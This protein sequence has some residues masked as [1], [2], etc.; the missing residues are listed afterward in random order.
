[1]GTLAVLDLTWN[2]GEK[3]HL[4][5]AASNNIASMEGEV[6]ALWEDVNAERVSDLEAEKVLRSLRAIIR[7][8]TS[9]IA[10]GTD[11]KLNQRCTEEAYTGRVR[12]LCSSTIGLPADRPDQL[13]SVTPSLRDHPVRLHPHLLHARLLPLVSAEGDCI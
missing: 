5:T 1:M 12:P 10:V 4:L 7:S 8:A 2:P 13:G 11:A 3:A 9:N 6:R